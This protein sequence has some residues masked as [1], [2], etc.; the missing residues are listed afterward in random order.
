[1]GNFQTGR[2]EESGPELGCEAHPVHQHSR[3][4]RPRVWGNLCAPTPHS[5]RPVEEPGRVPAP[6]CAP[7]ASWAWGLDGTPELPP[8]DPPTKCSSLQPLQPASI[9]EPLVSPH[10][11][12]GA[13]SAG[14]TMQETAELEAERGE[15]GVEWSGAGH[16]AGPGQ[17]RSRCDRWARGFPKWDASVFGMAELPAG[18]KEQGT[19]PSRGSRLPGT[20]QRG[21]GGKGPDP[22]TAGEDVPV[23]AHNRGSQIWVSSGQGALRV[24]PR[25][26]RPPCGWM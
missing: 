20:G 25:P 15:L 23:K 5:A 19:C 18:C 9:P 6:R 4:L 10:P 12:P 26:L 7:A 13:P 1:M 14:T 17:A 24:T 22:R 16:G 3:A 21:G 8:V 2:G 11:R